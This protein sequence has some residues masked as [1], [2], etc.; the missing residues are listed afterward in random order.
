MRDQKKLKV[1]YIHAYFGTTNGSWSSRP[2]DFASRWVQQGADI[3]VITAPY[4]KSDIKSRGII[5]EMFVNG[6]RVLVI[7]AADSNLFGF[8][9]RTIN[10]IKF[11]LLSSFLV[12]W[13]RYDV[14]IASSGPITVGLAGIMAK[15][16]RNSRFVFE[17]RDLWP[18]GA[19]QM[20]LLR[21]RLKQRLAYWFEARCYRNSNL[22]VPLST[23]MQEHIQRRFPNVKTC[24][25]TNT[26]NGAFF[27]A[28]HSDIFNLPDS[29]IGKK[30]FIYFGSLGLMDACE[31]I[32]DAM[33]L[34]RHRHDL[35]VVFIG[36]GAYKKELESRAAKE[37][38]LA[39]VFFMGLLPKFQLRGWLNHSTA[40]MV[41]F[42]SYPVLSTV[43]PNKMF[44]SFAA[45][46][47]I[48]QNTQGWIKRLV[49]DTGCGLTVLNGNAESLAGAMEK[50]ADDFAFRNAAANAAHQLG[51]NTF[52][53]NGR[54]DL[55][56]KTLIDITK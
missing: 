9:R 40:S 28:E 38:L 12:I 29:L 17:V 27:N 18:E 26:S 54:A 10:A 14:V 21:S 32:I 53:T 2:Y 43:S 56:Y 19:V 15:W 36:D 42:K 20:G 46:L 51:R 5:S 1:A 48:I 41:M 37:G 47:P 7:D 34:L 39:N 24:V 25:I 35:A 22:V 31:D 8:F 44:D 33:L 23:G 6:F 13:K 55:Y 52:D 30:V 50:M 45:G 11:A 4:Y 49:S 3:T 16:L